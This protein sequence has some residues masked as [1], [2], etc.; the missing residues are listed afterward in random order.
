MDMK[1]YKAL[2]K[3]MRAVYGNG[4]QFELG[5]K[6]TVT[7]DVIPHK[8]GFHFCKNIEYLNCS[9]N[10]SNSRIFEVEAYGDIVGNHQKYVAR[11]ICLKRELT[12]EEIRDYFEQNQ[13]T[14]IG[15]ADW[16]VRSAAAEQ[17]YGL[18]VLLH[19][20]DFHVRKAVAEQGYGLVVLV[21]DE[22]WRVR[23]AVAEQ[24]FCLAVLVCDEEWRVRKT[25]AEQGYGLDVLL[26]DK[27]FNVRRAAKKMAD[28]SS[29]V[30]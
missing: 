12:K 27:N 26:H 4:M 28:R 6:Y 30:Q 11:G 29:I 25:V 9:Y 1:G 19:D 10:I 20:G 24:G 14:V 21:H 17:G 23:R 3:N 18:D 7:G 8:N 15:N 22:E 13:Q 5:K 2:D 16:Q